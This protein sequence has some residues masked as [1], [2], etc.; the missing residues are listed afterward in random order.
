MD[1]TAILNDVIQ[2]KDLSSERA[3]E[4][5]E[6]IMEGA[7]SPVQGGA[8][9]TALRMKGESI[10]EISGFIQKMRSKMQTIDAPDAIDIVGTGGGGADTFNVSTAAA[11]VA[12]GAGAKIAKHGNRAASSK[13]G[14]ADVLE[15]LGVKIEL[16][17]REAKEV[18]DKTGII[19]L[20]APLYHPAMKQ[21]VMVRKELKIRTIFNVLGPFT[22]PAGTKRQLTGVLD[23]EIAAKMAEVGKRL[24]YTHLLIVTSEDG[25]DEV[26]ISAKTHAFEIRDEV[27]KKFAI[28]PQKLG[29][30]AVSKDVLAGGNKEENAAVIRDVLR[31]EKGPK[32][33]IVVLNAGVALYVAGLVKNIEDGIERAG[34]SIDSGSA[35]QALQ[36]LIRETNAF[37]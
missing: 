31:G 9:L 32:R 24:G 17:A 10:D 19:F 3:G 14:S 11:F 33:D 8:I 1:A 29:F 34:I 20:F 12:R 22:N 21:V 16:T 27:V 4:L 6:A 37:S 25:M 23:V 2:K 18:F 28:D 35:G 26:S 15:A 30:T 7:F 36:N 13:C 5:L